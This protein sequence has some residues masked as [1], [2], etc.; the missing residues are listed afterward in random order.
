MWTLDAPASHEAIIKKSRFVACATRVDS[1]Q[2]AAEYLESL[3]D[4]HATHHCWA[5]RIGL[6]YR[7][8]DDGEPGG[9][10][11]RPILAAIEGQQFDHIMVVVVRFFGGI[12]L[13]AG[14]LVRAYGGVTAQCLR[15]AT[16]VEIIPRVTLRVGAPFH[17]LGALYLLF[18]RFSATKIDEQ[19][20]ADGAVFRIE[21]EQKALD[22]FRGAVSDATR[23]AGTVDLS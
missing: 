22:D 7:F 20:D 10:A 14:G 12:K 19:F 1:P 15:L 6:L 8:S 9:T 2:E 3:H 16:R 23:G 4:P 13:G 18:E 17:A 11:G 21:L 5:Y